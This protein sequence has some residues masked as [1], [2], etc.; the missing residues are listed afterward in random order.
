MAETLRSLDLPE[1]DKQ[2]AQERM[3]RQLTNAREW[4]DIVN[5]F[6]YRFCG[7]PDARGRT[8]YP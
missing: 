6:F 1:A 3:R 2:E 7:V 8:I 5:T 4:R